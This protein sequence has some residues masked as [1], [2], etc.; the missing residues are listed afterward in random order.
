MSAIANPSQSI[1]LETRILH[2]HEAFRTL[3]PDWSDLAERA[4]IESAWLSHEWLDCW[5]EAFG[6]E[7]R[8]FV[9]TIWSSGRLIAAAPM[10]TIDMRIK[11]LRWRVLRFMENGVTPRSQFLLT[12]DRT[13]AASLLWT[14][15]ESA[16]KEWDLAILANVPHEGSF[17]G[18]RAALADTRMRFIETPDRQSPFIDLAQG[19]QAFRRTISPKLRENINGA[20]NRLSRLGD[21]EIQSVLGAGDVSAALET[22]FEISARGW[23]AA[24]QSD[25][26]SRAPHRAFYHALA[27]DNSLRERLYIW[28]LTVDKKP[29]AFNMVIRSGDTVSGLA[30]D[31]D[32]EFRQCSPGVY[33]FSQLLEELA[34]L[35]VSRCDMAGQLHDY[36]RFWTKQYLAHSQFWVFHRAPK[37]AL[38]YILKSRVLAPLKRLRP[39]RA[40]A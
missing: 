34:T 36:K 19:F 40:A 38:L 9:P 8:L 12:P 5:W 14:L 28:I 25:L 30:T 26:G 17:N 23:K 11:G 37:S 1:D 13:D 6:G 32:L 27:D 16:F 33:L 4:E 7:G 20:R 15:I 31:Y 18:W 35:R 29:I 3:R 21:I 24:S 39:Q 10:M 2:D 22:C